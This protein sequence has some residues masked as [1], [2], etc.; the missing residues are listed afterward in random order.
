M[1][2]VLLHTAMEF[3]QRRSHEK[4]RKGCMRCKKQRKKCDEA[5]PICSRCKKR[6]HCC[7]YTAQHQRSTSEP[8]IHSPE[9]DAVLSEIQDLGFLDFIEDS[10]SSSEA[11][12]DETCSGDSRILYAPPCDVSEAS[13][14]LY[15]SHALNSEELELL[16]HYIT[17]TSRVIPFNTEELYALH[18]GIPNL[19]FGS[20]P[21]MGSILALS[22]VCKCYDIVRHSPTP[23]ERVGEI[24]RLLALADEHHRTSLHQIQAAIYGHHFDTVLANAPLMVLYALSDHCVRI[25]LAKKAARSGKTLVHELLPLQSQWITS[26]R[27][28]YVAYIGLLNSA[29]GD[30]EEDLPSPLSVSSDD[31]ALHT[32]ALLGDESYIPEDGPSEGTKNLLQPIVSATYRTA[33]EKLDTR[34]RAVWIGQYD[35]NSHTPEAITSEL[36][37]CLTSLKLLEELFATV[38]DSNQSNSE[39]I[40]STTALSD[41]ELGRFEKASP[42]LRKYMAHVT[43]ATPSKLWRRTIMAFVNHVPLEYL[44]IVQSALDQMPVAVNQTDTASSDK[45]V[46]L[47]TTQQLAMDIF[48]HWLVLVMLLDGVWWIGSIGQWELGRIL[49]FTEAQRRIAEYIEAGETWWPESMYAVQKAIEEP[50]E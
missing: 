3:R 41:V 42:W 18:V 2:T 36:Q 38:F 45:G 35:P 22:A 25:L 11:H 28:A 16:S 48:A 19:A 15:P 31:T 7:Q 10:P 44:Q 46:P 34:A 1:S 43:S 17:H 27:A 49:S 40:Q 26:I 33:L 37:A 23:L 6:N 9:Q 21:V 4:S 13:R 47:D 32:A 14:V 20:K 39:P 24:K 5:R 29:C 12:S 8:A 30:P 50:I